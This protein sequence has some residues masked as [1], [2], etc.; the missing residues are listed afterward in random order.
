MGSAGSGSPAPSSAALSASAAAVIAASAAASAASASAASA[1]R[2]PFKRPGRPNT[3][4]SLASRS[5]LAI[6]IDDEEDH[7]TATPTTA[8]PQPLPQPEPEPEEAGARL[9]AA[10]RECEQALEKVESLGL[11][12][13]AVR[14]ELK[15]WQA[16]FEQRVGRAPSDL[17]KGGDMGD[18]F[19][20]FQRLTAE[21]KQAAKDAAFMQ[22]RLQKI[23]REVLG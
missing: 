7:P 16:D 14:V 2:L 8:E 1:S 11:R 18:R 23:K 3:R 12:K 6:I 13:A 22:R 5:S 10:Q 21:A 4:R 15:E 19:S 20:A 17:D 9:V